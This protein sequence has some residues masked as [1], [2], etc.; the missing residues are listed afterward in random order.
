MASDILLRNARLIDGL[1]DQ[2]RDGMSVLIRDGEIADIIAGDGPGGDGVE[3]VDCTGKT[4]M[5]GLIDTHVHATLMGDADLALFPATGVT[6]AR[7]VGGRLDKVLELRR[8]LNEGEVFGPRLFVFGPLLDGPGNSFG[9]GGLAEIL[10]NVQSA[11][12]APDVVEH[13]IS[14]GVDG[15]K[16]YFSLPPDIAEAILRAVDKR[17]PTTGHLGATSAMDAIRFGIEGL[18]HMWISPYNNVCPLEM[19]FG[20]DATMMNSAFWLDTIKGWE[21]TDLEAPNAQAFFGAMVENQINMGTTLDL[22]W[23]AKS[24]LEGA[25]ADGDRAYIP[26]ANLARQKAMAKRA[27]F[28]EEWD[29]HPGFFP[30]GHGAKALEKQQEAVRRLHE[31][32]GVVIGGTDCGALAYPPP[33]FALL[34]EIGLL[35]D[36][37][38]AMA[39]LKAVT[40]AAAKALRK[41]DE[42]GAIAKG[43]RAD[44][45][46]LDADPSGDVEALRSLSQVYCNGVAYDPKALLAAHPSRDVV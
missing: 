36:A 13:L 45:L 19:R 23:T 34:R 14:S 27:N 15:I 1:A 42:I 6:T 30:P 10:D 46:V 37:I 9:E 4:L 24:G 38:G 35:A 39:A 32:G 25:L 41:Q 31:A 2:P 28:G 29:I 21:A 40:S 33:G 11:E 20:P 7:D 16:L 5:P 8:R 12:E 43:C 26:Q 18:E 17:V 22:L 3:V 44:I